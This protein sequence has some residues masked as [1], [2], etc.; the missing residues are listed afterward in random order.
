MSILRKLRGHRT[1]EKIQGPDEN[2]RAVCACG[3]RFQARDDR[4]MLH[5][6]QE[7]EK[8]HAAPAAKLRTAR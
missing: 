2:A 3:A 6:F 4:F 8:S 5:D 1:V 7:W